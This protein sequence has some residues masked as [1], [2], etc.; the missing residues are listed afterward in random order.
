MGVVYR[1]QQLGLKRVVALKM[2]LAGSHAGPHQLAR[3][4]AEAEA[5]AALQHP[6]IVQIYEVGEQDGL[7]YFSLEF[8]EG[9]SLAHRANGTP[10]PAAQAAEL[11]ETLA[12]AIQAAHEHGIIH[13]DLKP[14]NVLLTA[15]GTPKL[16]DFGLAKRLDNPDGQSVTG[17]I[18]GTPSY[19]APEQ[20]L[21]R[22]RE[23]GP[24]TD[25]Y[26]LGAI[27]Y[28]LL[29][30]RPPFKGQTMSDTLQQVKTVEPV[31]PRR[32]QPKVP[33]DLETICLKCLRKE[34]RRRYPTALALASDLRRFRN[35]EP[36][37]ARPVSSWERANKW[38]R[39][40]PAAAAFLVASV[41][42]L[43]SSGL[44]LVA[45]AAYQHQLLQRT[46]GLGALK[47]KAQRD[48]DLGDQARDG[49]NW[50]QAAEYFSSAVAEVG[51]EPSLVKL[52]EKAEQ[53]LD[54]ARR[55]NRE[56]QERLQTIE[57]TAAQ[58]RRFTEFVRLRNEAEFLPNR[59]VFTG[60]ELPDTARATQEAA[61]AAL[62]LAGIEFPGR[63]EL[64]P[65]AFEE[66][67][68]PQVKTDCYQLLLIRADA[69]A[70]EAT[71]L[72]AAE[73]K[74]QLGDALAAL[75]LA[76]TLVPATRIYYQRRARYLAE[77]GDESAAA[78]ARAKAA[79]SQPAGALDEF[80]LGHDEWFAKNGDAGKPLEHFENALR[81]NR[82]HFW[83]RL[84]L[85]ACYQR[86][87]NPNEAR[88]NL[89]ICISQRPEF[90]WTY[91]FR[92]FLHA[93]LRNFH[94]AESDFA[95]AEKLKKDD[96]A[97][98][99]LHVNRAFLRMQQADAV[100]VLVP[101]RH[102][103]TLVPN[104]PP[105]YLSLA[106]Y[107]RDQR[108]AAAEADSRAAVRLQAALYPAYVGLAQAL[109]KQYNFAGAIHQMDEA[110]R[111]Q[112]GMASLYRTRATIHEAKRDLVAAIRDLDSVIGLGP[113][114]GGVDELAQDYVRRGYFRY[115]RVDYKGALQ[116]YEA[117]L[118][119][120]VNY[121]E[122]HRLRAGVLLKLGRY[123]EAVRSFDECLRRGRATL[124]VLQ[125]QAMAHVKLGNPAGVVDDYTLALSLSP[126]GQVYAERGWAYLLSQAP[127]LALRDFEEA[128]R[129]DPGN[130]NAYCGRGYARAKVGSWSE[131]VTDA[132]E[133]LRLGPKS[134]LLRWN[135]A[136][137]FAVVVGRMDGERGPRSYRALEKRCECQDRALA[138]LADVLERL[139]NRQER[140]QFWEDHIGRNPD[141]FPIHQSPGFARLE[142][143]YTGPTRPSR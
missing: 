5:V 48:I 131:A 96:F 14:L 140:A 112:P 78:T 7:P 98:Y 17:D 108:L 87:R 137:V 91:L 2:I 101:L 109:A 28:E 64:A 113:S 86:L 24:A 119:L 74:E 133:A 120:R 34:W 121:P 130:A 92:G 61:Q 59:G 25:I 66:Q 53:R 141:F 15:D 23:I 43:L 12:R 30:G 11:V 79:G 57:R 21:G 95:E 27:L 44:A 41:L 55:L 97:P 52:K 68:R 51:Q 54:E 117:A 80:F 105:I 73:R 33:R 1:A 29:T 129:L 65:D 4:R 31:P 37:T 76:A 100:E 135:V 122:A 56:E 143:R 47:D 124:E 88:A 77:C 60:Q 123:D 125:G 114:A 138:L 67:V 69:L 20:A 90:V 58:R 50:Q 62:K 8:V 83:A 128:I 127:R 10:Q 93:Q 139:P 102:V 35:G 26:A 136:R 22:V 89:T 13:R 82:E 94:A 38:A 85:A 36:I 142:K 99:V 40:R 115:R 42:A 46:E 49:K 106:P 132:E 70:H 18:M 116:D 103:S 134:E 9:G 75:D 45:Y 111:L 19:M 39:R 81:Q 84:F 118:A 16:T 72:S 63:T 71:A 107:C 32:L 6:N 104:A 110:I 126:D 3:F